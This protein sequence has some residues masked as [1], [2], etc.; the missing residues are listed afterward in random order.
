MKSLFFS[1]Y[2][3][4]YIESFI[5]CSFKY[6]VL[7]NGILLISVIPLYLLI[8]PGVIVHISLGVVQ[9]VYFI[10]LLTRIKSFPNKLG[11][12]LKIYGAIVVIGILL[13]L[14]DTSTFFPKLILSSLPIALYFL[15]ITKQVEKFYN[16]N[17]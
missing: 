12:H 5:S 14:I 9:L 10:L 4:K 1:Y 8:W 6:I 16:E 17:N 11:N 7:I 2:V 15:Y 13:S 3:S